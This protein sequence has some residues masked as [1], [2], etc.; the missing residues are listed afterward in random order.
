MF[1]EPDIGTWIN[2]TIYLVKKSNCHSDHTLYVGI[3]TVPPS[4]GASATLDTT[5]MTNDYNIGTVGIGYEELIFPPDRQ[6]ISFN[7]YL[8]PDLFFEGNE[9]FDIVLFP[10]RFNYFRVSEGR[11]SVVIEDNDSK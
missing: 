10:I 7:F 1:T 3:T 4:S 6:N 11:A 2:N 5:T 8:N 9:G